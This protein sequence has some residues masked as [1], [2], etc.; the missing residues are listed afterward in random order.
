MSLIR[1]IR[2]LLL[3]V[4]LLAV[5]GA[6]AVHLVSARDMAQT[7]LRVKNSDNAQ[8]LALTL[9]QQGGDPRVME[10]AM[11]AQFDTGFYRSV[12]LVRTDGSVAFE[13]HAQQVPQEAPGWFIAAVPIESEPGIA[14]VSDGWRAI[15]RVE[16]VSHSAYAYG[17]LWNA[18]L[19]AAGWMVLLA[20]VAV[21][22]GG[23]WVH[24]IGRPLDAAV[25]QAQALVEGRYVTVDE[26]RVPELSRL[27]TAMN[28]MVQRVRVLFE[29]QASQMESLRRQAHD[30]PLT[31]VAHRTYFIERL[32]ALAARED[33][34]QGGALVLVRLA[35]LAGLNLG[36]GRDITDRA[37]TTIARALQTYPEHAPECFVGRLNGSDFALC[38]P[39]AD[40]A[41]ETAASIANGLRSSLPA[42]GAGVLVHLGAVA[43]DRDAPV[44]ATLARADLALAR[45]EAHGPFAVEVVSDAQAG[46]AGRGERAWRTHIQ[47]AL[48]EGRAALVEY[49][50]VDRQGQLS[51]F[52]CP[53][54]VQLDL[55]GAYDT[56]ARW[57]PLAA[58]SRLTAQ[59]DSHA[60]KLAL[61]A[62]AADGRPRGVN[63]GTAS[64]SDPSFVGHLRLMLQ[65]AARPARAL[66][67]EVAESA[68]LERFDVVQEFGRLLRPLGVRFGLEHAGERLAQ[69]ER[70][71]ELGLDYVKLDAA[72]C[73]GVAGNGAA[74][75]FV[76]TTAALLHALS[77]QVH[78]E[79]V[80]TGSDAE[81][82]WGCG[83]D[84]ITGPWASASFR[85]SDR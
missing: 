37:L 24:R 78:A 1:Q 9:S 79:G 34:A 49:P 8:A 22:L 20:V 45:A 52:E 71:Y 51:H 42:L 15:G 57:L 31:G 48:A 74:R 82:L 76:R 16:V 73:A 10:L 43:I 40:V 70:L 75:D 5:A 47:A 54:R 33:G 64:F 39:Y 13:R 83:V 60:V 63:I 61:A 12:R 72:L 56:A 62:I 80:R 14:Q 46:G 23:A 65:E 69:V 6:M 7:Q 81:A 28:T 41:A 2:L 68:A 67:L 32:A 26:P 17:D 30:D 27:T 50:V 84:A 53:L 55:D 19:Q 77:V 66:W 11:A 58:R 21:M 38:L 85:P 44:G 18:M 59:V 35:D 29:S 36:L 3:A 25:A 4:V